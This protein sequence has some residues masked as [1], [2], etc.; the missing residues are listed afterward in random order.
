MASGILRVSPEKLQATA[1]R[2][3]SSASGVQ[4][5]TRR[6]TCIVAGLSGRVWS[7]QA[8]AAYVNKFNG[9]QDDMDR[10]CKMI[11][12]HSD[13]LI[14]MAQQYSSAES[15]NAELAGS[16]SSDVIV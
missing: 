5:L 12:E 8:A 11:R 14:S 2:F 1:S 9:L 7:G 16:L 4:S 6:M 15:A 3:E 10:I 13:D